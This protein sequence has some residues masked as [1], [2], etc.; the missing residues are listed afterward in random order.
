VNALQAG[1][2]P[3]AEELLR[4]VRGHDQAKNDAEEQN[5]IRHS[6]TTSEEN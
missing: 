5:S 1:S 3:P 2:I 6:S 4:A